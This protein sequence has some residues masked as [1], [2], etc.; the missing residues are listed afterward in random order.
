MREQEIIR[1][2]F[3]QRAAGAADVEVG[4]GDDAAVLAPPDGKLV[5]STDTLNAGVHFFADADPYTLARKAAAVSLSDIA[6]MGGQAR[7]LTVALTAAADASAE[8]F[9]SFARG[10]ASSSAEH[11]YAVIGGD[12]TRGAQCAIT[13]TALGICHQPPLTRSGAKAGDEVWLSGSVGLAAYALAVRRGDL[14]AAGDMRAAERCLHD[15]TP[16]LALAAALADKAHAMM[17]ISDGLLITAQTI[18]EQSAVQIVLDAAALPLPPALA[19]LPAQAAHQC[20]FTGGDDYELLFTAPP[21]ANIASLASAAL[22]LTRIGAV[23]AGSGAIVQ[24]DGKP[25]DFP[26]AGYSHDFA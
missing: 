20:Q 15:P 23:A 2:Y 3:A 5:V 25:L 10:L 17:D 7:W 12:L 11:R 21:A 4:V 19:H 1:R 13:T 8:W 16:R 22:P 14:P 24:L 18:A 9:E 26:A 6:A